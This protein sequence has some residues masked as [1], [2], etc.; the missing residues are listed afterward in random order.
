MGI[1]DRLE[2]LFERFPLPWERVDWNGED[3]II[4]AK[5]F[6]VFTFNT[7]EQATNAD[8]D[9]LVDVVNYLFKNKRT[10]RWVW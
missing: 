4:C 9:T 10:D 7:G 6:V 1:Q 5:G 3:K 8:I 2:E